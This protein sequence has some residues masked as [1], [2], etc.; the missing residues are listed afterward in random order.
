MCH[1]ILVGDMVS[2][3]LNF[4]QWFNESQAVSVWLDDIR[5]MPSQ[6]TI[7]AKTAE[8]AIDLLKRGNVISI[9]LDHDLGLPENGTGYD[10]AKWIEE[11]A[12]NHELPKLQWNVHSA[13]PVGR[14]RIMAALKNADKFWAMN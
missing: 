3:I 13:N 14:Q 7:H 5:P 12:F 8:A 4:K 1:Y 6:Y 10:V 11:H 9:S 2:H